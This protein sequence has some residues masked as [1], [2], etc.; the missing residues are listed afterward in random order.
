M[1]YRRSVR[2]FF[3][4]F[5]FSLFFIF[6][7]FFLNF[8]FYFL[9]FFVFVQPSRQRLKYPRKRGVE[10]LG[11]NVSSAEEELSALRNRETRGRESSGQGLGR[12]GELAGAL[13]LVLSLLLCRVFSQWMEKSDDSGSIVDGR[14]IDFRLRREMCR[15]CSCLTV[16]TNG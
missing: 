8:I 16:A 1:N 14:E 12:L 13:S 3:I 5:I 6:I 15:L 7:R 10:R 9:L 4:T 2:F 11:R